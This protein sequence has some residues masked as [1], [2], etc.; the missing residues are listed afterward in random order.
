MKY[1]Q[2]KKDNSLELYGNLYM[3]LYGKSIINVNDHVI[4]MLLTKLYRKLE[5]RV[6]IKVY[7]QLYSSI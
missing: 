1:I 3:Q 4:R 5:F 7:R 6:G 2:N